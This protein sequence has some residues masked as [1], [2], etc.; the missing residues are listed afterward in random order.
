MRMGKKKD[1]GSPL[2]NNFNISNKGGVKLK[3]TSETGIR[4]GKQNPNLSYK[5]YSSL[6]MCAKLIC[7]KIRVLI[8]EQSDKN[9]EG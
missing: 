9:R 1:P 5:T 8:Q 3:F 2:Q 4:F 6:N 7:N